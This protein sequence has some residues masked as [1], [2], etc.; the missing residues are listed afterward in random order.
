MTGEP[1]E[2]N[3][4]YESVK[5]WIIFQTLQSMETEMQIHIYLWHEIQINDSS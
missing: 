4:A 1:Y 2:N 3:A 5:I